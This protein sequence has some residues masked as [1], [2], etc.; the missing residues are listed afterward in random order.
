MKQHLPPGSVP[1]QERT[2]FYPEQ[3]GLNGLRELVHVRFTDACLPIGDHIHPDAIELCYITKGSQIY[4]AKESRHR[5]NAG[6]VYLAYP[7]EHHST[8]ALQQEKDVELYYIIIDTV[9]NTDRFLG[10]SAND[11]RRLAAQLNGLNRCFYAGMELK[12]RFDEMIALFRQQPEG[13]EL[14]L[15]CHVCLMIHELVLASR[16]L[17]PAFTPDILQALQYIED[18][19][20]DAPLNISDMAVHVHLSAPHF[21]QKFRSQTGLPPAA[22][23]QKRRIEL[24]LELLVSG[25]SVTQTAHT[26]GFSSSQHFATTFRR[27]VGMTPREWKKSHQLRPAIEKEM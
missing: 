15:R 8:D 5:V 1:R 12:R 22:Y 7:N 20:T 16:N 27:Y 25:F 6:M 4:A 10:L 23:Q 3:F 21:K 2:Q 26:L 13:F 14:L 19:L 18:H 11:G 9:N 17:Q 24:S